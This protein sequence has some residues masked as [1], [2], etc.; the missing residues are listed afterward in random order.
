[1][2]QDRLVRDSMEELQRMKLSDQHA[3][4]AKTIRSSSAETLYYDEAE[5]KYWKETYYMGIKW[6]GWSASFLLET[7]SQL[8]YASVPIPLLFE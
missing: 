1:M 6:S 4:Q 7:L 2:S 3:L 5:D 8:D